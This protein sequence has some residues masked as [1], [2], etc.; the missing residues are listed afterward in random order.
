MLFE[1]PTNKTG[2]N[3]QFHVPKVGFRYVGLVTIS[4]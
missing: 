4:P 3:Y 2:L 1:K